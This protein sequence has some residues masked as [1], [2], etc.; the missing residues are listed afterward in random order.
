M[1]DLDLAQT[2]TTG[3]DSEVDDYSVDAQTLDSVGIAGEVVWDNKDFSKWLGY[4]KTIPEFKKAID[5]LSVWTCGKGWEAD[6]R[7]TTTLVIV[8]AE[9]IIKDKNN[10]AFLGII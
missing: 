4:Y 9:N 10:K 3:M 8:V 5:A 7:T 6:I 1:T 2:T